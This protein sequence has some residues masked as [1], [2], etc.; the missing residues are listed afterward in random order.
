[1]NTMQDFLDGCKITRTF[2]LYLATD[3]FG[4]LT[5]KEIMFKFD[6]DVDVV[7]GVTRPGPGDYVAIT[8]IGHMS[9]LDVLEARLSDVLADVQ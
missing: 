5:L 1:M 6:F 7:W 8:A 9:E 4:E 2:E 3:V